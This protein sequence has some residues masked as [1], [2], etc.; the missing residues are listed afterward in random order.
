[1]VENYSIFIV[2]LILI[3]VIYVFFNSNRQNTKKEPFEENNKNYKWITEGT[4]RSNNLKNL[5]KNECKEY[6]NDT[7]YV[8]TDSPHGPPG[9]WLVLGDELQNVLETNPQFNG[10]GFGCW[11]PNDISDNKMCSVDVPCICKV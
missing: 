6:L 2:L 4:C 1:M 7:N 5:N 9:C 8:V 3:V 10:K 11:A